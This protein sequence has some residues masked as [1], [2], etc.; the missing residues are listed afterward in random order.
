ML[1]ASFSFDLTLSKYIEIAGH[2]KKPDEDILMASYETMLPDKIV[3]SINNLQQELKTLTEM[4]DYVRKQLHSQEENQE[5][6][7]IPGKGTLLHMGEDKP[8]GEEPAT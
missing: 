1:T 8:K 7:V 6:V 5:I 4:K 3:D 2:A